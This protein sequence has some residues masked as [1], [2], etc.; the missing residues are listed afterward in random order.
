MNLEN[1]IIGAGIAGVAIYALSRIGSGKSK[2][3]V[4]SAKPKASK[5]TVKPASIT[6]PNTAAFTPYSRQGSASGNAT[7]APRR[8]AKPRTPVSGVSPS[9][10][11]H[12]GRDTI[13]LTAFHERGFVVMRPSLLNSPKIPERFQSLQSKIDGMGTNI[14]DGLRQ[15]IKLACE[16]P[17]GRRKRIVLLSD[18][19][20]NREITSLW[21]EVQR[22]KENY[23]NIDAIA[24][25]PDA[26]RDTLERIANGTHRGR[27]LPVNS[28]RELSDALAGAAQFN[29]ARSGNYKPQTTIYCIDASI[30]MRM[31][32]AGEAGRTRID[33]VQECLFRDLVVKQKAFA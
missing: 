9:Y 15:A 29:P 19:G 30:S 14:T 7:H 31:P 32:M 33:V 21:Q 28:L 17:K 6:Q 26:P 12:P 4:V 27:M 25:G 18:G 8:P 3:E 13:G 24:F 20:A 2:A 22:A 16:T 10:D 23:I 11:P 5:P 1:L